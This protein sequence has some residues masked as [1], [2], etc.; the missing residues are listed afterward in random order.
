MAT[1]DW[2]FELLPM[3]PR[4]AIKELSAPKK[5]LGKG[6]A[7]L[8]H[9]VVRASRPAP[10]P[11]RCLMGLSTEP[12]AL[13]SKGLPDFLNAHERCACLPQVARRFEIGCFC[14]FK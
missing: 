9:R 12:R 8:T 7:T 13:I 1:R 6:K 11:T 10:A 2:A 5:N 3:G 4:S 14:R